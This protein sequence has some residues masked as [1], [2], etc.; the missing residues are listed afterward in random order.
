M[1]R[2]LPGI[3]ERSVNNTQRVMLQEYGN[4]SEVTQRAL[5]NAVRRGATSQEITGILEHR[6]TDLYGPLSGQLRAGIM[7]VA[8][9]AVGGPLAGREISPQALKVLAERI[10]QSD[11]YV[12]QKLLPS[13]S[14]SI[15][16]HLSESLDKV[17]IQAA[18]DI[19]KARVNMAAGHAWAAIGETQKAALQGYEAEGNRVVPV[20][21]ELDQ[22]ALHCETD[23]KRGTFG[24]VHLAGTYMGGID[25]LPTLPAQNTTCALNCVL[26]G[27]ILD[28]AGLQA[29]SRSWY[30]GPVLELHTEK[31]FKLSITPNHPVLTLRGWI[32]AK[33]ITERDYVISRSSSQPIASIIN[34]DDNYMPTLAEK[35]WGA[36]SESHGNG[37]GGA[38]RSQV[39]TL[40]FHGDERFVEGDVK[41]VFADGF[42]EGEINNSS[43]LEHF[44]ESEFSRGSSPQ[45]LFQSGSSLT[46][47]GGGSL[48]TPD[49][50][51]GSRCQTA[52][53]PR[54]HSS[55]SCK[56]ASAS[57]SWLDALF[58]QL[59]PE[60]SS[61]DTTL[62][63]QLLLGLA[64]NISPD[65]IINI[66]ADNKYSGHVY[67]LQTIGSLYTCNSVVVHN[68]RCHLSLSFDGGKTFKRMTE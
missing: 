57:V 36:L 16:N 15:L 26:P 64:S 37:R 42:L 22:H 61:A 50:I 66:R 11:L 14:D 58:E 39:A 59:M 6:L 7:R 12:Q 13:I 34:S 3:W 65:K 2:R 45:S 20:R 56:H 9:Q 48:F 47:I 41:I 38:T 8:S 28:S 27:N 55:H 68:C 33:L 51:M 63:R 5:V 54:S 1:L 19:Q 25:T 43:L 46:Q 53:L 29:A 67:D 62:Q 4:W 17:T 23:M 40:D 10:T 24:C 30:S 52:T 44:S 49:G 60:S 18:L 31:G 21:W 32:P 35:I